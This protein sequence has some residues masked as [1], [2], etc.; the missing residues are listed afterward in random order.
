MARKTCIVTGGA[1]FIGSNL[2]DA[3]LHR[4][5][6]VF[7]VDNLL[8]G[9]ADNLTEAKK[10]PDFTFINLDVTAGLPVIGEIHE[11]YHL[12][13]P[14]SVPDY[15]KYAEETALVNSVGT[16][17][18]LRVAKAHGARFLFTSTSEIYGDPKE[19]PQKESYWGNVN[20]SGKR[21][22]SDES[23]RYGEMISMLYS[24]IHGVDVRIARIFNTYGPR[25]SPTDGRVISNFITQALSGNPI[26][27]YGN[28]E[29]TRSFCY[30]SDMVDG[31][32]RLM[33]TDTARGETV[34]LGN[35]DEY[36]MNKLAKTVKEMV[37]SVSDITYTDLPVDD[38]VRRRPDISKAKALLGWEPAVP[39]SEGLSQSVAYY[40][41]L[42][43]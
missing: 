34:N 31:L 41:S 7:A 10:H 43:A 26:T 15:Q 17:N 9:S 29:Q 39:L 21:A 11:I 30:V 40:R 42:I 14:A 24:R 4:G 18:V 5:Y 20:P 35:P 16:R 28:G 6:R 13:S 25:M 3:L 36:S 37:G 23:K 8:T 33:E 19:H 12:A 27:V 2:V 22:C 1:G 32:I 38:P